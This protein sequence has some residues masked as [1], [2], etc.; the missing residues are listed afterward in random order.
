MRRAIAIAVVAGLLVGVLF[1]YLWW[2]KVAQRME[3]NLRALQGQQAAAEAAR[4]E[5]KE[6]QAKLKRIEDEL[7]SERE[8]RSRLE[9]T[10]S[11]GRK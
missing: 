3:E 2:G 10:I 4:E 11:Q 1:G 7:R 8:I 9:V 5:L 6:L